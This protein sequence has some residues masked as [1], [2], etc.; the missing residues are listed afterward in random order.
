MQGELIVKKKELQ[1]SRDADVAK[2]VA[3][4][5]ARDLDPSCL[6]ETDRIDQVLTCFGAKVPGHAED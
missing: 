4:V 5:E 1:A 6:M 2:C 3:K